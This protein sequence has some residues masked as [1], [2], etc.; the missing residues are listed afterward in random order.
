MDEVGGGADR[1][2]ARAVR[3]VRAVGLHHR[4]FRP[5]LPAVRADHRRRDGDLADRVADAVAGAVRDAAQ[6]ASRARQAALVVAAA[7]RILPLVQPRLRAGW[8][9]A[10]AGSRRASCASRSIMLLV[11]VGIIALRPERVPQG[12]D[13]LHPAARSRLHHRRRATAAGLFAGAHRRGAAARRRYRAQGAGRARR[14]EHRRLLRRDLHQRA[15]RRR[16]LPGARPVREARRA[17]RTSPPPPSSARCS[18]SWRASRRRWSS[19]CCRRRLPASATP[20]A[21]A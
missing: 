7:A 10:M 2:R 1:D 9:A 4:H 14:G 19:W 12:A 11:Y 15:E 3:G 16:G 8:P 6:A 17:I 21:S 5:V 20:A 18:A 13:R